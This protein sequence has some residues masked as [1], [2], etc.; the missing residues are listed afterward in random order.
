[1]KEQQAD[2]QGAQGGKGRVEKQHGVHRSVRIYI[3][4]GGIADFPDEMGEFSGIALAVEQGEPLAE[5]DSAVEFVPV[6]AGVQMVA[7]ALGGGQRGG[8]QCLQDGG[9]GGS[10]PLGKAGQERGDS[11]DGEEQAQD[12]QGAVK[13]PGQYRS[14]LHGGRWFLSIAIVYRPGSSG[15]GDGPEICLKVPQI[16]FRMIFFARYG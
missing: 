13:Q 5:I 14:L 2:G 16:L 10:M 15:Q 4:Q 1:M 6:A 12:Q 9:A 3:G 8:V 7:Q 11:L